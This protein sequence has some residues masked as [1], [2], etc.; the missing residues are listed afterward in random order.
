M[1]LSLNQ[2]KREEEFT[3]LQY[4]MVHSELERN[5]SLKSRVCSQMWNYSWNSLHCCFHP[6][7]FSG[8]SAEA[9]KPTG[10]AESLRSFAQNHRILQVGKDLQGLQVCP[11]TWARV[12][13]LD[14]T[15]LP[16][17]VTI[18]TIHFKFCFGGDNLKC[19]KLFLDNLCW[20]G[21]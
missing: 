18:W 4:C 12:P 10:N 19:F 15:R 11:S 7:T 3:M 21:S 8:F 9:P 20:F 16:F 17:N 13:S 2:S 14:G 5:M 6:W 1:R